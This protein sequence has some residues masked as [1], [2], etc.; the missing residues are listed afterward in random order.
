MYGWIW[1]HLPFG[2]PGKIIGSTLLVTGTLALLWFQVFPA[3]EPLMPFDEVQVG[4]DRAGDGAGNAPTDDPSAGTMLSPTQGTRPTGSPTTRHP[5]TTPYSP[6]H[7]G[8][9]TIPSHR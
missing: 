7:A 4:T 5:S 6:A 9:P 1:R 2:L 8:T 3:I